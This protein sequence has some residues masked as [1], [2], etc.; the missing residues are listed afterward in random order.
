MDVGCGDTVYIVK[1]TPY[2]VVRVVPSTKSVM[3]QPAFDCRRHSFFVGLS[4]F[5]APQKPTTT[6]AVNTD[7]IEECNLCFPVAPP[8]LPEAK[9]ISISTSTL[10]NHTMG[11]NTDSVEMK[12]FAAV[13]RE[14][15]EIYKLEAQVKKIKKEDGLYRLRKSLN[16]LRS[17][18]EQLLKDIDVLT[19]DVRQSKTRSKEL[20]EDT[21]ATRANE[22]ALE[23]VHAI[24]S[25]FC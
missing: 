16:L 25:I 18:F 8:V 5:W 13:I 10:I 6:L 22:R 1:P 21:Q 9:D 23:C 19:R 12:E 3:V 11:C 17:C 7:P 2:Y 24:T 4:T 15:D 20:Q 14:A